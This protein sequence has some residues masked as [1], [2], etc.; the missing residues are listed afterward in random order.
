MI[1]K[2]MLPKPTPLH[3][4]N[5]KPYFVSFDLRWWKRQYGSLKQMLADDDAVMDRR[6]NV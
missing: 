1:P 4:P 3:T 5:P 2:T 6:G